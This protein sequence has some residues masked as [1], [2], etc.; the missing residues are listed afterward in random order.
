[1]LGQPTEHNVT[2]TEAILDESH[3]QRL[4]ILIHVAERPLDVLVLVADDVYVRAGG[5]QR[6]QSGS[7]RGGGVPALGLL[8]R[9]HRG[10]VI[11]GGRAGSDQT[12]PGGTGEGGC[13]PAG[14]VDGGPRGHGGRRIMGGGGRCPT[15][16]NVREQ[17]SRDYI[18]S[19][20]FCSAILQ[21]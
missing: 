15:N 3:G 5:G 12:T 9:C 6:G 11:E 21:R 1:M 18:A 4:G 20:Y 14:D 2:G 10:E 7:G 19:S 13:R 8:R 17:K 16:G